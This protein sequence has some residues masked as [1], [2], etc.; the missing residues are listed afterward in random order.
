MKFKLFYIYVSILLFVAESQNSC[1]CDF[2]YYF[3][4]VHYFIYLILF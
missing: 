3:A 4:Y 1:L 2:A